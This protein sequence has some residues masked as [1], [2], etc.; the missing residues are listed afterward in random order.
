MIVPSHLVQQGLV[1][2]EN[3]RGNGF[4]KLISR[5]VFGQWYFKDLGPAN[6]P[7]LH[8]VPHKIDIGNVVAEDTTYWDLQRTLCKKVVTRGGTYLRW[9]VRSQYF[10][11]ECPA[12]RFIIAS[13]PYGKSR[14]ICFKQHFCLV[15]LQ[16]RECSNNETF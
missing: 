16:S 6:F 4:L 1:Q 12:L 8:G 10:K 14:C 15:C 9:E 13:L 2:H 11:K 7:G 5:H 3:H